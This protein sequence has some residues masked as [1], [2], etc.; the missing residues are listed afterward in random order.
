MHSPHEK[1]VEVSR[2][3]VETLVLRVDEA[4]AHGEN[5]QGQ[6]EQPSKDKQDGPYAEAG[7]HG[8]KSDI[9]FKTPRLQHSWCCNLKGHMLRKS[10]CFITVVCQ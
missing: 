1:N 4:E 10:Q 9:G 8:D 5:G 2:G 7:R 6:G 3:Q